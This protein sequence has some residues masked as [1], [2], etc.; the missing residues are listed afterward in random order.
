MKLEITVTINNKKYRWCERF[1]DLT[2]ALYKA[3]RDLGELIGKPERG[4]ECQSKNH[5]KEL[6]MH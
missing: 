5:S 1:T 6:Q 4:K 3:M 2:I